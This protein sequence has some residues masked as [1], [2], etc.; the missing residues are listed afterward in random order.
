MQDLNDKL[1]GGTLSASEWN[2]VPSELQNVIEALGIT[3]S[4]GDTD[5]LGKALAGYVANG[6][7]YTDSGSVNVHVLS[8]IG[9]KQRIPSYEDGQKFQFFA[10]ATNTGNATVNVGG[11]GA[12]NIRLINGGNL[13]AGSIQNG[14]LVKVTYDSANDRMELDRTGQVLT[15]VV[16][17][18]D[19]SWTPQPDTKTIKFTAIGAGGGGGGGAGGA[20]GA[21]SAHGGGG[22]TAIKTTKIIDSSYNITIGAGGIGGAAGANNGSAGG[23]TTVVGS[24][25][26]GTNMNLSAGG[27]NG[28]LGDAN[29]GGTTTHASTAGGTS[30]GGDVNLNGG[31][32]GLTR[33]LT[34]TAVSFNSSGTSILGGAIGHGNSTTG[35]SASVPGAGGGGVVLN[36][37][38]QAGGDGAD[39]VVIVEEW[40]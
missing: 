16:I 28:G 5:Q 27:G 36:N 12:K 23:T 3:L 24:T 31:E 14:K 40:L 15:T 2:Q 37:P 7:F 13:P 20:S 29:S 34:G 33:K 39:G 6:A 17:A 11:L 21:F 18:T 4:S 38:S 35:P 26:P 25:G 22:G 8:V 10:A 30:S 9:S 19:A 1:T 32:P